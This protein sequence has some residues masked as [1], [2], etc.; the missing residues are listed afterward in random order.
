MLRK[1]LYAG[2]FAVVC[3]GLVALIFLKRMDTITPVRV[4]QAVPAE[5]LLVIED[6]DFEYLE[7]S[8]FPS[9]RIW[10]DFINTTGKQRLDSLV[11]RILSQVASN[12]SLQDLLMDEGFS[13]SLHLLG[14][15]L[16]TPM[17]YV[18]YVDAYGDRE[19]EEMVLSV[20]DKEA[21]VN[22][23][24]YEAEI[25]YDVSGKPGGVPGKFTFACV[26]GICMLSP[27]SLLVEGSV[28]TI[29]S[30]VDEEED[31]GLQAIR[32][33]AG[34]YVHAN[35]YINYA[36]AHMLFYPFLAEGN[37]KLMEVIPELATWGELDLDIKDDAL[38]L[39]GM[40]LAEKGEALIL[41]AFSGQ[42]PVK[43]ELHEMMPSGT[44]HFIHLGIS[45]RVLF[46]ERWE[47]YLTARG[48]WEAIQTEKEQ[49]SQKYGMD[50]LEDLFALMDDEVAWFSIEGETAG[51][52]EEVL[53]VEV[54][55]HSESSETVQGW[56]EHYLREN[57]FDMESYRYV[58]RLDE[59]TSFRIYRMPELFDKELAPGRMLKAYFTVYENCILF[60]PSVEVLSRVIYQN[61]LHKTFV[62]DPVFKEMSDYLSNR[63][64]ITLFIRPFAYLDS[65]R[66]LLGERGSKQ[67][68]S[69]ELFLRRIPGLVVQYNAED[70]LFYHG[71]S[72]KYTSQIKEK[73]L[74]VWESLLDSVAII[75]PVLVVNHNTQEKE[76]FI[77]DA[78][79][80]IYLVNSTGRILWKQ[81]LEGP[82]MGG[83]FQVDFYKNGRLQYLFNTDGKL[84]LVDRNGNY[85]ERYPV[86]FR[87]Q[88]SSPMALFDYDKSRDYRIF[89][90]C[91][92]R[93]VYAYDIEGNLVTGWKFGKTESEVCNP[94]QHF[95]IGDLD[96]I[97]F[98]DGNRP[99]ILD[100]RGRER[101]RPKER[102]VF[103]AANSFSLD[104]NIR[105]EK[106]R[107]ISTD[108]SGRVRC[109]YLDGTVSTLLEQEIPGDHFFKMQDMDLDGIPDFI[110]AVDNELSVLRQDGSRLFSYRVR[111]RISDMPD[112]YK[113]SS[114]DIKIGITDRSRNR[115]YLINQDGSLYEGF[116]LEGSTRFSIGYFA[117]SDS[118]FNLIVGSS[119]NFLYNYSIE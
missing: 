85:V 11:R 58:Y 33:T 69:M 65:K 88:A 67:L 73:A 113:F 1:Y 55:S 16:L 118:R 14:K 79:N 13:V 74:T 43:M 54:R 50:P 48:E 96:Y 44:A 77:Q 86:S 57:A 75:K 2:L 31:A 71:I 36:R 45:D 115:I 87:A 22:E 82:I 106:P 83:V 28:R 94:P 105:E 108:S 15:N 34:K 119:N 84:H 117:G 37:W 4:I 38:V 112:I 63:S 41:G 29:H 6:I 89:V 30:G 81:Q 104:M 8:F 60:G 103:S 59:Q 109:I 21:M 64:N 19:F 76:I 116:P 66:D 56:I 52:D 102:V 17:V 5:A 20:L 23:R 92:D 47:S 24:R 95:R 10:I 107:W 53:M 100:R 12:E 42:S 35:L 61:I 111:G 97:V 72:C 70:R 25:L 46:R 80:R 49:I 26:N 62:S 110:F 3:T 18:S 99:Y 114:S 78:S 39:N 40:T 93:K 90:A 101:V 68:E 27:S 91:R 32:S 51:P 98:F 9:N 7:E